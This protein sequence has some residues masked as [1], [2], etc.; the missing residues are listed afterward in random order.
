[1]S[2][3]TLDDIR[4]IASPR[5]VVYIISTRSK[6]FVGGVFKSVLDAANSS[7]AEEDRL[8]KSNLFKVMRG[9]RRYNQHKG[10]TAARVP[11]EGVLEHPLFAQARPE[12]VVLVSA[13]APGSCSDDVSPR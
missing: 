9:S 4:S 13:C 10:C 6:V 3:P 8:E 1:M 2:D 7:L 12:N 11:A 5:G